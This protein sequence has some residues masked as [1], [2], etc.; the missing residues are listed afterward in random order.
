MFLEARHDDD[1]H[2]L[3]LRSTGVTWVGRTN[4]GQALVEAISAAGLESAGRFAWVACDNRTTRAVAKVLREEYGMS[5]RS[6]RAQA[7]SVA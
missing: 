6:M 5:R 4:D 3:V 7:Y 1:R 2:L